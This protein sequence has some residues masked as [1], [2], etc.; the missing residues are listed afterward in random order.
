[1]KEYDDNRGVDAGAAL[2]A[3]DGYSLS[4]AAEDV[5]ETWG[6]GVRTITGI[7]L[8][9]IEGGQAIA[10]AVVETAGNV[11]GKVVETAGEVGGQ[12]VD[13]GEEVAKASIIGGISAGL[14]TGA[15]TA[16]VVIGDV[17]VFGGRHL[18]LAWRW[19]V[20]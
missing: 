14:L 1:M 7:P 18:K 15:A 8:R 2:G 6:D 20:R 17:V 19:L 5:V 11:A 16:G 12:V 4:D 9:V 10:G 3:S 13:A